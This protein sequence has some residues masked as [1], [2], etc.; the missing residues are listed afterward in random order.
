MGLRRL[1]GDNA[2]FTLVEVACVCA[3]VGVL[4][5]VALPS[6]Q[7]SLQHAR[8]SDAVAALTRLQAAQERMRAHHGLY[9]SDFG[10]LQVAAVS[11]EQLYGLA[12]ELTGPDSYRASATALA[13]GAQA[14]DH[15]CAQLQIDVKSGFVETGPSP[16]CWNR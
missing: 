14:G 9:S 13:G 4:A 10:A 2:G 15:A 11:S 5:S 3:V 16:R 6:Y 8:R 7:A 12:I 1:R